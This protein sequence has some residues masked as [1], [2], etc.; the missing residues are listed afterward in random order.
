MHLTWIT[1]F[2]NG[3]LIFPHPVLPALGLANFYCFLICIY[4]YFISS[5]IIFLVPSTC[6]NLGE[7]YPGLAH[8]CQYIARHLYIILLFFGHLA[9]V[10]R[11][12]FSHDFDRYYIYYIIRSLIMSPILITFIIILLFSNSHDRTLIAGWGSQA[13]ASGLL[14]LYHIIVWVNIFYASSYLCGNGNF[15][16]KN[17]SNLILLS[18]ILK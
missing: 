1:P 18:L 3:S 10:W 11:K 4:Y 17:N 2:Y 16:W 14:L 5:D 9:I 15:N 7:P 8:V 12:F 13:K 6:S